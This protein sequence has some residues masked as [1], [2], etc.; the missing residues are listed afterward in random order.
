M[1][2]IFINVGAIGF[3]V[4][5]IYQYMEVVLYTRLEEMPIFVT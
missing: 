2:T 1:E 3:G 5:H 4:L